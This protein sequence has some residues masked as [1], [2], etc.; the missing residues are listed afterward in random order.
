MFLRNT[1]CVFFDDFLLLGNTESMGNHQACTKA[2]NLPGEDRLWRQLTHWKG[3]V[4]L[5]W[6]ARKLP[7]ECR[8][9]IRLVRIVKPAVLLL[10]IVGMAGASVDAD[11][12]PIADPLDSPV[13]S[14]LRDVRAAVAGESAQ[15]LARHLLSGPMPPKHDWRRQ[16]LSRHSQ[17]QPETTPGGIGYGISF[18]D[19]ALLWTNSTTADYYVIAPTVLDGYVSTLYLTS[20]CRAQLGTESL[21]WYNAQDQAGFWIYDWSQNS[22]NRWQAGMDNLSATHPEYLT[23]RPDEFGLNRQMCHIRNGTF[24][25]GFNGRLYHWQNEVM[26]FNFSRGGWDLIYSATYTTTN[27]TEDLYAAGGGGWWGPIVETFDTYTNVNPVGFDLIRLFQDGNP[28]PLWIT[29]KNATVS[30]SSPWQLLTLAPDTSFTVAVSPTNLPVGSYQLGTL[31]VTATTNAAS[32]SLSPT[33][34][35]ASAYWV[36]TPSSNTWDKTVVGLATGQYTINFNPVAGLDT[37][38]EQVLTIAANSIT[39][40]QANYGTLLGAPVITGQGMLPGLVFQ[41]TFTGPPGQ[42]YSVRG[43]NFLTTPMVPWPV[44]SNGWFGSAGLETF[45]DAAAASDPVQYYRISSP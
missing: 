3:I 33:T 2:F 22:T 9:A 8:G 11:P 13:G 1:K 38:G 39:T 21:I 44:L 25:E 10:M 40:V 45:T 16:P 36:I 30:Q 18:D 35:L 29:P 37:P 31:C 43:T 20:T 26:L 4:N 12:P 27:L 17:G 15:N 6:M 5:S 42:P 23:Q 32:F 28:N 19:S 41:M 14:D 7:A 34:G 24:Y